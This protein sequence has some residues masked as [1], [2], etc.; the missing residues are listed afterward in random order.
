M[1]EK[2][3]ND[4]NLFD[5]IVLC[6]KA[7]GK[8]FRCCGHF[9]KEMLRLSYRRWY[10]VLPVILV[11][12]AVALFWSRP[13]NRMYKAGTMVH[14][15]GVQANDV[16]QQWAA[17]CKATPAFVSRQ[18]SVAQ[19]LQIDDSIAVGLS[20][21]QCFNVVD[22]KRDSLPDF[23]DFKNKHSLSDTVDVVMDDYLYLQFRTK[24]PQEAGA[25]GMAVIAYLNSN[26]LMQQAF[27]NY[28]KSLQQKVVFC[29][30]QIDIMDSITRNFYF[31]QS[32]DKQ[33]VYQG[34]S[35]ILIG[36][37]ELRM[38][39]PQ[40]LT[41]MDN[42]IKDQYLYS[43]AQA[44]V[45]PVADF[46]VTPVAVNNPL[47]CSVLGIIIGYLI[48]CLSALIVEQRKKLHAWLNRKE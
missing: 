40:I 41:L 1:E 36:K 10:I 24:H 15:N 26:P 38:L 33:Y 25:T 8:L 20:H 3:N 35:S 21:F 27:G 5:L 37:R 17:L 48:G 42:T 32:P 22:C 16:K 39:H 30:Q 43:I 47:C 34:G 9:L 45:V 19:L 28:K 12:I 44:P 14:L 46:T 4:M 18:Q 31:Q 6:C 7:V 2:K 29:Q 13:T 23:V 11:G